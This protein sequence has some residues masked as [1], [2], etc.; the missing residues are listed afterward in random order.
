MVPVRLTGP[1]LAI[2][3]FHHTP[4]DV[5]A[6]YAVFGDPEATRYLPFEARDREDCA[7]QI[8]QYLEEAQQEERTVYRLAVTRLA[9]AE[10]PADAVP[11]G[12]AALGLGDRR[13]ASLGYALRRDVWGLGYAGEITELLCGLAFGALG[14]HRLEARVDVD[15]AASVRVLARA[16]FRPEGRNRHDVHRPGRRHD[17]YRYALLAEEWPGPA[18]R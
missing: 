11:I 5:E 15:N 8:E 13:S 2:R 1:R 3:E 7:D 14:V 4:E 16:G 12:N 18:G 10:D 17:S 9:D 6:L